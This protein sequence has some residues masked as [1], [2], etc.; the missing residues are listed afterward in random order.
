[1]GFVKKQLKAEQAPGGVVRGGQPAKENKSPQRACFSH[2]EPPP[3]Y[4]VP[5]Q[6]LTRIDTM[7]CNMHDCPC[8]PDTE[9]CLSCFKLTTDINWGLYC[10]VDE[11]T[12]LNPTPN[13]L[14]PPHMTNLT[15]RVNCTIPDIYSWLWAKSRLPMNYYGC[16]S[17]LPT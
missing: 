3:G 13:L 4:N 9:Q 5:A 10:C 8:S 17:T 7:L 11:V 6:I 15:R 12:G 2:A 14:P 16:F 1:M